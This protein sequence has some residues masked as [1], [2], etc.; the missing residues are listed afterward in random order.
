MLNV[1]Q[2]ERTA[3]RSLAGVPETAQEQVSIPFDQLVS[4]SYALRVT[5]K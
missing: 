1:L 5:V 2:A 3:S 4:G